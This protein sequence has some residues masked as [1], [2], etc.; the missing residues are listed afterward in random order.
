MGIC[1]VAIQVLIM[2]MTSSA[3][4]KSLFSKPLLCLFALV[5]LF[6]SFPAFGMV[7][8]KDEQLSEVTGQALLQMAKT[9]GQ[10]VSSD[11]T[12]YKAGLDAE[13]EL[14]MNIEKLQLGCTAGAIN[15][16]F[17]DIDIDNLSL[18]GQTWDQSRP[19]S[20]AILT[21]PF[22]EFAIK[23]DGSKTLREVS[24]IRLS[25]E[26]VQGMLTAG[27]ENS[28]VPNGINTISGYMQVAGIPCSASAA[29]NNPGSCAGIAD[30]AG[31][32]MNK[33][34]TGKNMTG[35]VTI[36]YYL[37]EGTENYST[38][39]YQINLQSTSA[40][41]STDTATVNGKRETNVDVT[42]VAY[43]QPISITGNM[44]ANVQLGGFLPLNLQKNITGT[45]SG[46]RANMALSE[47]LGFVHKILVNSPFSLSFQSENVLWPDA[48]AVAQQG[49][50]MAFSDSVEI[51]NLSPSETINIT[52]QNLADAMGPVGCNNGN[53]PG[54]NCALYADPVEC[55]ALN[56]LFGSG[57][58]VGTVNVSSTAIPFPLD[59]LKL[60][61]QDFTPNCYGSARF[62]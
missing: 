42:G 62:C 32:N 25:A 49:W 6:G 41:F 19:E 52:D 55:G 20:S 35:R 4:M 14:N 8:M 23:N 13:L 58:D 43:I 38:S 21:R 54:I 50:W 53:A 47:D 3:T 7:E 46:L 28:N 59:S 29:A 16:Q 11:V 12:F 31:R 36:D 27:L 17:C 44:T 18:S 60:Q 33:T 56:C 34:H 26:A 57:L 45:I 15:G 24:G 9:E 1:S 37:F 5:G 39:D 22:F 10:D 61:G 30:V 48:P 40:P 51:G 2:K